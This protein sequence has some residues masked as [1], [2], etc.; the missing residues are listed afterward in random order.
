MKA[1]Q[2]LALKKQGLTDD[3]IYQ[4]AAGEMD[5]FGIAFFGHKFLCP[6]ETRNA[7]RKL[8]TV[9]KRIINTKP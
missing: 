2:I 5:L 4:L 8:Q 6:K 7:R 9:W 3:H 1:P